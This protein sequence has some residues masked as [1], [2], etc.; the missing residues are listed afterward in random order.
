LFP[1]L[2]EAEPLLPGLGQRQVSLA[3]SLWLPASILYD[4]IH[5]VS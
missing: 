2:P 1:G 3:H 4:Y 5:L